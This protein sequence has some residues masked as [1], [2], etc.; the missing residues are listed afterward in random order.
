MATTAKRQSTSG[1][2]V[3]E[4]DELA[5]ICRPP[6]PNALLVGSFDSIASLI[7]RVWPS[8]QRPI[9]YWDHGVPATIQGLRRGT[10]VIW[11]VERLP[12]AEQDRLCAFI[13]DRGKAVQVISAATVDPFEQVR[14]GTFAD[15]LYYRLNIVRLHPTGR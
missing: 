11:A 5:I 7:A 6:F 4:L 14:R 15:G 1:G 10:L 9:I 3:S 13:G 12:P 2:R 8:L